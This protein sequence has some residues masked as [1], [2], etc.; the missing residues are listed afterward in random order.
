M[1]TPPQLNYLPIRP[2]SGSAKFN[3]V[4]AGKVLASLKKQVSGS[5]IKSPG[6]LVVLPNIAGF[7]FDIE[8]TT[9]HNL[10]SD[11]TDHYVEDNTAIQD[12]I[13]LKPLTITLKNYHGEVKNFD[14]NA[15]G[16][17]KS[18]LTNLPQTLPDKAGIINNNILGSILKQ[19]TLATSYIGGLINSSSGYITQFSDFSK[20]F[21]PALSSQ[22]NQIQQYI[23]NS[24]NQVNQLN[25]KAAQL[26]NI[27]N[28]LAAKFNP[29][30]STT[31]NQA[32]PQIAS[33]QTKEQ[34]FLSSTAQQ[35]FAYNFFKVLRDTKTLVYVTT[36][37]GVSSQMAIETVTALQ[38]EDTRYIS[39]FTITLKEIRIADTEYST[40]NYGQY[41]GR[42]LNGVTYIPNPTKDNGKKLLKTTTTVISVP[43]TN[44]FTTSQ[45]KSSMGYQGNQ[46]SPP[47]P[48]VN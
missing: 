37:F 43:P 38:D 42:Y 3:A 40:F 26:S 31:K 23:A 30:K 28:T 22:T 34:D 46:S 11:I 1:P 29:K 6:A 44:S 15:P 12:H 41:A 33:P 45:V 35:A 20:I 27:Y 7:I 24:Q 5:N 4:N 14:F 32:L 36:C 16:G 48:I 18:N 21:T 9:Q 47:V 25:S 10:I 2:Q 13:A 19:S 39:T 17:T 8:G